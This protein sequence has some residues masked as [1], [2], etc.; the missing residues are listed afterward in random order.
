MVNEARASIN[1]RND[2]DRHTPEPAAF[3]T[4]GM[5]SIVIPMGKSRSTLC[6]VDHISYTVRAGF[7]VAGG[8]TSVVVYVAVL[9]AAGGART[10]AAEGG[11]TS[12]VREVARLAQRNMYS[13]M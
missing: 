7:C 11:R 10:S 3:H 2:T 6:S 9:V 1:H 8:P 5:V 4:S 13:C 12:A